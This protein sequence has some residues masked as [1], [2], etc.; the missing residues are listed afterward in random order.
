MLIVKANY[1]SSRKIQPKLEYRSKVYMKNRENFLMAIINPIISG[2]MK[3][4]VKPFLLAVKPILQTF[5]SFIANALMLLFP[6]LPDAVDTLTNIISSVIDISKGLFDKISSLVSSIF[7]KV[8][9]MKDSIINTITEFGNNFAIVCSGIADDIS[10]TFNIIKS[11]IAQVHTTVTELSS[12]PEIFQNFNIADAFTNVIINIWNMIKSVGS[13]PIKLFNNII[14]T[15]KNIK[16]SILSTSDNT[17][18]K[19]DTLGAEIISQSDNELTTGIKTYV[20]NTTK[21]VADQWTSASSETNNIQGKLNE[22][23][24]SASSATSAISTEMKSSLGSIVNGI[25]NFFSMVFEKIKNMGQ[26]ILDII[27]KVQYYGS[28]KYVIIPLIGTTIGCG[29]YICYNVSCKLNEYE[30]IEY[31]K[32]IKEMENQTTARIH[33]HITR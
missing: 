31:N 30:T 16:N 25:G 28:S 2:I 1:T 8:M 23:T 4:V 29:L 3:V 26:N 22:Y 18:T 5:L 21:S 20:N 33:N 32:K 19:A 11:K 14:D 12:T 7:N 13:M 15:I 6:E 17:V 10:N 24:L 27:D 9:S